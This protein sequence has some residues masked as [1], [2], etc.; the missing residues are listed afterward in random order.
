[1]ATDASTA[2]L[3]RLAD[4]A[5]WLTATALVLVAALGDA[6]DST[7]GVWRDPISYFG[8]PDA[9]HT[10]AFN[11]ALGATGLAIVVRSALLL[12]RGPTVPAALYAI[13][14][15]SVALLAVWPI[16]CSPVDGI[17]EVAIRV[18]TTSTSHRI[19]ARLGVVLFVTLAAIPV[20]T[21]WC[22]RRSAASRRALA[23]VTAVVGVGGAIAVLIRQF[24]PGSG[25]T[26]L[27]VILAAISA[28]LLRSV[29][30]GSEPR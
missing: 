11:Y 20:E 28:T 22:L 29:S 3:R 12:A 17:C 6:N 21:A 7:H 19:H 9:P 18:R 13:V 4:V 24:E 27:L 15:L 2:T 23:V 10:T 16:D 25:A 14:G 30:T 5:V 8:S 26:E 1:M